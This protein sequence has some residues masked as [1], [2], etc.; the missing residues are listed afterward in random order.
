MKV[1]KRDT[2][3]ILRLWNGEIVKEVYNV[4]YLNCLLDDLKNGMSAKNIQAKYNAYFVN[5][6]GEQVSLD[7]WKLVVMNKYVLE[8]TEEEFKE[9]YFN[10]DDV[11][12]LL[13][14]LEE[15][16]EHI[17]NLYNYIR[18]NDSDSIKLNMWLKDRFNSL[19]KIR[20]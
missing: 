5:S 6:K 11:G 17:K 4:V 7:T 20:K 14:H 2:K 10:I 9:T 16:L 12:A 19:F 3:R 18:D 15:E 13:P 1:T 8:E